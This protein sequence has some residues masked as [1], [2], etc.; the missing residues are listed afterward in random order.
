LTHAYLTLC[1]PEPGKPPLAMKGLEEAAGGSPW[2]KV[3]V[4]G[5]K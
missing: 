5:G 1:V 4:L 3:T 2:M